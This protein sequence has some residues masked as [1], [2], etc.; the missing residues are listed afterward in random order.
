M[1]IILLIPGLF[2][3]KKILV[4]LYLPR[5]ALAIHRR[6][7]VLLALLGMCFGCFGQENKAATRYY[8]LIG[9][10]VGRDTLVS[11]AHLRVLR[12]KFEAGNMT[13]E[14]TTEYISSI[15]NRKLVLIKRKADTALKRILVSDLEQRQD[16]TGYLGEEAMERLIKKI[17]DGDSEHSEKFVDEKIRFARSTGIYEFGHSFSSL[18][19]ISPNRYLLYHSNQAYLKNSYDEIMIYKLKKGDGHE[20]ERHFPISMF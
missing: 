3:N 13:Q 11:D 5:E 16:L 1:S 14:D 17:P 20:L 12:S 10:I 8:D 4:S 15:K 2:L 7:T 6:T 9:S 18:I 19:E